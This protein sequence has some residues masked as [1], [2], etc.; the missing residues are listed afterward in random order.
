MASDDL[1][2]AQAAPDLI[3]A[4]IGWRGWKVQVDVKAE[5]E[6]RRG[7]LRGRRRPEQT[8]RPTEQLSLVSPQMRSTWAGGF[9]SWN[10]RCMCPVGEYRLQLAEE[11]GRQKLGQAAVH[12]FERQILQF[13]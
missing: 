9:L 12:P 1:G 5:V 7:R 13:L 10:G 8:Q 3:E 11:E 6:S 4:I 2:S